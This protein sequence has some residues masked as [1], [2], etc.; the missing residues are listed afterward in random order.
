M[1]KKK[2]IWLGIV[3]VIVLAAAIIAGLPAGRNMFAAVIMSRPTPIVIRK[4]MDSDGGISPFTIGIT[5][6]LDAITHQQTQ[7][8][9]YCLPGTNNWLVEYFCAF[10]YVVNK[11][12]SCNNWCGGS[13]CNQGWIGYG[14]GYGYGRG[15]QG[16]GYGYGYGY[17]K[18]DIATQKPY[19]YIINVFKTYSKSIYDAAVS[20][21]WEFK[22]VKS[23]NKKEF[24][25]TTSTR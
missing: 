12:I 20:K 16:T 21:L 10:N 2:K 22:M 3:A 5:Q 9:D 7:S 24:A 23:Y 15:G 25:P 8:H 13:M 18:L 4:C 14:Y 11:L 17:A 6:W 19:I 1:S